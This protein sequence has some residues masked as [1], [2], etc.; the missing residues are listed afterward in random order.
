MSNIIQYQL[1]GRLQPQYRLSII[2]QTTRLIAI[3]MQGPKGEAGDAMVVGDYP[4]GDYIV[5]TA[6]FNGSHRA[7]QIEIYQS[8]LRQGVIGYDANVDR[9]V[10]YSDRGGVG[11]ALHDTGVI[12]LGNKPNDGPA[13]NT[14]RVNPDGSVRPPTLGDGT[15]PLN[16]LYFS[17]DQGRLVYKDGGGVARPLW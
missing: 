10:I 1:V 2:N 4:G 9:L 14:L 17:S 8:G 16:S 5:A 13:A 3:G 11:V 12:T 6:D 7:P 15:A